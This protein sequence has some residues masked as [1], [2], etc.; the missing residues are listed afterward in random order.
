MLQILS[1]V[2]SETVSMVLLI[3]GGSEAFETYLFKVDKIFDAL[4][5][6]SYT[7]GITARKPLQKPYIIEN[8]SHLKVCICIHNLCTYHVN[9]K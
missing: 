4:N 3:T 5:V 9:N 1:Q 2:M 6:T 8:D 7:K